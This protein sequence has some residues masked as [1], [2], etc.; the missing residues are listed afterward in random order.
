MEKWY[1]NMCKLRNKDLIRNLK[2]KYL[3]S[4]REA[5]KLKDEEKNKSRAF[6]IWLKNSQRS[7]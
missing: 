3:I 2:M 1:E 5:L 6:L 7:P 4:K